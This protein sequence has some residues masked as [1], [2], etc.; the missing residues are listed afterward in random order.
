MK[1]NL[2]QPCDL[3]EYANAAS[4]R[5]EN[6]PRG[7]KCNR[8]SLD[9]PIP[10]ADGFY[11]NMERQTV[12][13]RCEAGRSCAGRNASVPCPAGMYSLPGETDCK[14][15]G[16]GNY[17]DVEATVCLLCPAGQACHDPSIPPT[18]CPVGYYSNLGDG[19][20]S[21]C[22][23]GTVSLS[24]RTGCFPCT[25]GYYCPHPTTSMVPCPS[26]MYSL[27]AAHL[28]CT[29]CPAGFAC[30]DPASSPVPCTGSSFSTGYATT[31]QPCP[32]GFRC[33]GHMKIEQCPFDADNGYTYSLDSM[34]DCK[35]CPNRTAGMVCKSR[36]Q[37]PSACDPG[38]T[39]SPAGTDCI[40]CSAGYQ[41]PTPQD[42]MTPCPTGR[43]SL[44][45]STECFACL[46]GFECTNTSS[47]PQPCPEGSYRSVSSMQLCKTCP[48]GQ[49]CADQSQDPVDC[50]TGDYLVII[51]TF[52]KI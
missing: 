22:D 24:N 16:P 5:C 34:L 13:S 18:D 1:E 43:W 26:G 49:Y 30:S 35:T 50:Q 51:F 31:C 32:A 29:A 42:D 10:C 11:S 41:C 48:G 21:I 17:S 19:T 6:C 9:N 46:L 45:G 37:A 14:N 36:D 44:A 52:Q 2:P 25:A 23:D 40:I 27:G 39:I 4:E 3:G 8:A 20:C 15:C 12:C 7:F 47:I 33:P 38:T 28:N